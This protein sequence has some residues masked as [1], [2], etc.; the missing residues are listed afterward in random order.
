MKIIN[1]LIATI[2]SIAGFSQS[3][4]DAQQ[5][6]QLML[7]AYSKDSIKVY[8]KYRNDLLIRDLE[9]AKLQS[10]IEQIGLLGDSSSVESRLKIYE[11]EYTEFNSFQVNY[12]EQIRQLRKKNNKKLE[13]HLTGIFQKLKKKRPLAYISSPLVTSDGLYAIVY[14]SYTSSG[15]SGSGGIQY[16]KKINNKWQLGEYKIQW[17]S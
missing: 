6:T 11:E 9:D 12:F 15:L 14:C 17:V 13:R 4:A 5:I 8:H 1:L 3:N 7:D 10:D 16:L 2:Y